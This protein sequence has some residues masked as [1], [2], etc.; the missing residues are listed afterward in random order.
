M[1]RSIETYLP[2]PP[3]VG[4]DALAAEGGTLHLL[5][6]IEDLLDA[7][8]EPV[9][10]LDQS[11]QI[12]LANCRLANALGRSRSSLV[13]LRIGEAVGCVHAQEPPDGCGTTPFCRYCGAAKAMS[14]W[15]ATGHESC[16][17]C[18]ITVSADVSV[19]ALD[20][21][22][23][24]RPLLVGDEHFMIFSM[25]DISAEKRRNVLE[26]VFFHDVL[27]TAGSLKGLVDIWSLLKPEEAEEARGSLQRLSAQLVEEIQAQ[28]ELLAAE[29]GDLQVHLEQ[30]APAALLAT[31]RDVFA[32]HPAA[33]GCMIRIEC[34]PGVGGV[35]SDPLLLRR[36]LGN[37]LKNALEASAPGQVVTLSYS[38]ADGPAFRTHNQ[39]VMPAEV[40]AQ[41]FQRSFSTKD[42]QGRGLG[43][44]GVRLL[45]ERYLKGSV[46][47]TSAAGE[48]TTFAL[49]LPPFST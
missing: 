24:A 18:R 8:P 14:H 12:V 11:R 32:G 31:L 13:G 41:V 6:L 34:P 3:R 29:K 17:E 48:G 47:F 49:R 21:R 26:D 9:V 45:T 28:R 40:S 25:H 38:E 1:P 30:V 43:T 42:G 16:E 35:L 2:P 37:L 22:V 20:L 33:A 39:S 27:N 5:R 23:W 19:G 36:V 4:P 15:Q 7:G 46:A 44:Y 10:I